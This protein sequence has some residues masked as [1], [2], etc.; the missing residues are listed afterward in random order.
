MRDKEYNFECSS[1]G[2]AF[3]I[4]TADSDDPVSCPFCQEDLETD[5][6]N[7]DNEDD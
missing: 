4:I 3:T 5:R 2:V 6:D 1:C 7:D